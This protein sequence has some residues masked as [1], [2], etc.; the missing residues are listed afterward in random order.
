MH[1]GEEEADVPRPSN[2]RDVECVGHQVFQDFGVLSDAQMRQLAELPK[3]APFPAK[4]QQL[5]LKNAMGEECSFHV[6]S[7]SGLDPGT[8]LSMQKVRFFS[9]AYISS[10][11]MLLIAAKQLQEDQAKTQFEFSLQGQTD[12][13]KPMTK[14]DLKEGSIDAWPFLWLYVAGVRNKFRRTSI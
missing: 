2:V 4:S 13:Y 10:E 11:E 5:T 8:I 1:A 6:I 14:R 3:G 12:L 9:S 7:L